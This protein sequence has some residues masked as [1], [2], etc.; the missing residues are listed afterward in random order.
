MEINDFWL[1]KLSAGRP[2]D[3]EFCR[4]LVRARLITPEPILRFW[5]KSWPASHLA[6]LISLIA[7]LLAG[8]AVAITIERRS[9][10]RAPAVERAF[11][12][13]RTAVAHAHS[14]TFQCRVDLANRLLPARGLQHRIDAEAVRF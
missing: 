7:S 5:G 2:K 14:G 8:Y 12:A 10:A 4:A 9:V 1:T 3:F 6:Q 11:P 13:R